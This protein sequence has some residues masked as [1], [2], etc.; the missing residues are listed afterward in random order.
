MFT[1]HSICRCLQKCQ[2]YI[3]KCYLQKRFLQNKCINMPTRVQCLDTLLP[4]YTTSH[5][6]HDYTSSSRWHN[7]RCCCSV[8]V[9]GTLSKNVSWS[10]YTA[11]KFTMQIFLRYRYP[12]IFIIYQTIPAIML[13]ML[14][15]IGIS[16]RKRLFCRSRDLI[17]SVKK[18][19]AFC[20]ITGKVLLHMNMLSTMPWTGLAHKLTHTLQV[21]L[22]TT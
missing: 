8:V 18:P 12:S 21:L 19:T 9:M 15:L 13:A 2:Q 5:W 20:F 11:H 10:P 4:L 16:A 3:S 17:E 1:V 7:I 14:I 22:F 6:H